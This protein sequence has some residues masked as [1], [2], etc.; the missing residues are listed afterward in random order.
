MKPRDLDSQMG[1]AELRL[2]LASIESE[3]SEVKGIAMETRDQARKTNGRVSRLENWRWLL[4][5][6]GSITTIVLL[7]ILFLY[8]S[9]KH[10]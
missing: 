10:L 6:M 7:P 2:T 8:I 5:G 4:L 3:I 1:N 9:A